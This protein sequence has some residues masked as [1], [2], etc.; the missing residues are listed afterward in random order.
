MGIVVYNLFMID[1]ETRFHQFQ[2]GFLDEQ[3][4]ESTLRTIPQLLE[5]PIF[6]SW[7]GS[8]GGLRHSK[9]FL[10]LIDRIHSEVTK[11]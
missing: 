9:D 5:L 6:P 10:D 1:A 2:S 3:P 7:R 4:W 11:E 8:I